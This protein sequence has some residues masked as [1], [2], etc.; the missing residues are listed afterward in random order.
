MGVKHFFP[1]WMRECDTTVYKLK[2]N[3]TLKTIGAVVD[4]MMVDM[5]G[6]IHTAAQKNYEYG[7]YKR[8]KSLLKQPKKIGGIKLQMRTFETVCDIIC[9]LLNIVEP[10]KELVLC[11]D[12]CAPIGKQAQQRQRRFKAAIDSSDD[13]EVFD[14]ACITP[15]TKFMDY[16]SKYMDWFIRK[17]ITENPKWKHLKVVFS[18][19]KVFGEGEHKLINYMRQYGN[20]DYTYCLH[21]LDADLIMLALGTHF[22]EFFVLR[23]SLYEQG[24]DYYCLDV[25]ISR[26]I[27]SE[28]MCWESDKYKFDTKISIDDF[29][30]ICFIVGNDF[31]PHIPSIEIIEGGIETMLYVYRE[32]G[33][34]FGHLLYRDDQDLLKINKNAVKAFLALLG[35]YEKEILEN[36]LG[37]KG[38]FFTDEILESCAVTTTDG[39][40]D[41]DIDKYRKTY[42]EKHFPDGVDIEEVCHQYLQGM[43]WVITYYTTGVPHWKWHYPYH[44]APSAAIIAQYVDT[45]EHPVW[46]DSRPSTP[47]QQL[48]SVLSPKSSKL[49]PTPL[50]GLLTSR[51]SPLAKFFPPLED[52]VIN[53]SGKRK[54]WESIVELPMVEFDLVRKVYFQYIQSIDQRELKR[55]IEGKTYTYKYSEFENIFKSYYGDIPKCRVETKTITL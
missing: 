31:L 28:I 8:P 33:S 22:P 20:K 34:S 18:N 53:K 24:V 7:N 13:K 17:S 41:L 50:D 37:H 32:V 48:L 27:L 10:Q 4:V 43:Q 16:L 21:G 46:G 14:S 35:T 11:I 29:I 52:I 23:D 6:I 19:E 47:F 1:W 44:Y 9:S 15:G 38:Q 51:S 49:L 40:Y 5:N 12:G 3:D 55:N 2:R 30:F 45:F 36:K 25:G 39:S 42:I 54:E 26:I